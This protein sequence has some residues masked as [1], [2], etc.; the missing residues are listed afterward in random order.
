[1]QITTLNPNSV[2]KPTYFRVFFPGTTN[3]PM[4][5]GLLQFFL[6]EIEVIEDSIKIIQ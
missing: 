1:M 4:R 6:F 3:H 5:F 2:T